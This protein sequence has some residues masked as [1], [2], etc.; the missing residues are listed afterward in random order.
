MLCRFVKLWYKKN[1]SL[2][3]HSCAKDSAHKDFKKAVGAFSVTYDSDKKQL[4]ILV[5]QSDESAFS[6]FFLNASHH[7][8]RFNVFLVHCSRSTR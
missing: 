4:V 3:L 2:D 5:S 6:R 8:P 1:I 7:F